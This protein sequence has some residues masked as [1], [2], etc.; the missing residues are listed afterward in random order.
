MIE[1]L[2][3]EGTDEHE[4]ALAIAEA[5]KGYFP[6]ICDS[7]ASEELV[8]IAAN[9]KVSGYTI[10][11]IDIVLAARFGKSRYFIPSWPIKDTKG[12]LVQKKKVRLDNVIAALEVKSQPA[13][14]VRFTGDDVEVKYR[15]GWKSATEQNIK[16]VHTL[17]A[18][19]KQQWINAWVHRCVM[20]QGLQELKKAAGKIVP[21][22]G[23]VAHA[24]SAP[25]FLTAIAGVEGLNNWQGKHSLRRSCSPEDIDKAMGASVFQQIVPSN[26][27]LQKMVRIAQRPEEAKQL[28]EVL[29]TKRLHLAGHGGTGKTVLA[30]QVA[31]EAFENHGKRTLVVTYNHALAADIMR[32]L[33]LMAVPGASEGGGI[34]V[35]TTMSIIYSWLHRLEVTTFDESKGFEDYDELCTKALDYIKEGLV[36]DSDIEHVIASDYERFDFDAVIIDEAQDTPQPE[37]DLLSRLYG[38]DKICL[39][40]GREQLLRGK[41]TNWKTPWTKP[42][43]QE[44]KKLQRCLRMKK[45]LGTFANAVALRAGLNWNVEANDQAAGGQVYLVKGSFADRP[46]LREQL[47]IKAKHAGTSMIDWLYCVP[48]GGIEKIDGAKRSKLGLALKTVGHEVWDAVEPTIRRTFHVRSTVAGSYSTSLVGALKVGR[49]C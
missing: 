8:R 11:D 4:V 26:L 43:E 32:L 20:L 36:T 48:P 29:G 9:T 13:A 39:A 24:F 17:K 33:G 2:G 25:E 14:K 5:F 10:S 38:P 46:W 42:S 6:G 35:R 15:G 34:E 40:D 49:P 18:Y 31:H 7:P 44:F 27:D 3:I 37:A 16:Q 1:V 21:E 19:F 23:A 12:E 30:L 41:P 45:N 28:A 22:S 47:E